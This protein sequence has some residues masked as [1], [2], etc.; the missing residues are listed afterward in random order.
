MIAAVFGAAGCRLW[1]AVFASFDNAGDISK[2]DGSP[3]F[4]ED[5]YSMFLAQHEDKSWERPESLRA[6]SYLDIQ[7]FLYT[8]GAPE[9]VILGD[10]EYLRKIKLHI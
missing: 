1:L 8:I 10:D 4:G 9:M 2:E 5:L 6:V 7:G 3:A